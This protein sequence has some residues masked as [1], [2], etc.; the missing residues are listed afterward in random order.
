[1]SLVTVCGDVCQTPES[2]LVS[3]P[4]LAHLRTIYFALYK[5]II[6]NNINIII[7][8]Q[9][10]VCRTSCWSLIH[11][12]TTELDW[13]EFASQVQCR[14]SMRMRLYFRCLS[15]CLTTNRRRRR[16]IPIQSVASSNLWLYSRWRLRPE[17]LNRYTQVYE[18]R[19]H[20]WLYSQRWLQSVHLTC[21][22]GFTITRNNSGSRFSGFWN[23]TR[24]GSG[25]LSKVTE[26]FRHQAFWP[27]Y[28]KNS[29]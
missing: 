21:T 18:I 11:I 20:L 2:L 22:Y 6:I 25:W 7:I 5:C 17:H 28:N 16:S 10:H 13:I 27:T 8:N 9:W 14:S 19:S 29:N 15:V 23:W 4:E 1:M 26:I 3:S 24:V 12:V